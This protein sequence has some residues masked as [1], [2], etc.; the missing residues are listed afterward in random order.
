ML[1]PQKNPAKQHLATPS[2]TVH[3][4]AM[5]R[6]DIWFIQSTISVYLNWPNGQLLPATC[7]PFYI[8]AL[9]KFTNRL[10]ES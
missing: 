6:P 9:L 8:F 7:L 10:S 2:S 4:V 3:S 1:A 5:T